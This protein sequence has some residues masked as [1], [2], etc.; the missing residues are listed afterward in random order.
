[1]SSMNTQTTIPKKDGMQPACPRCASL[2]ICYSQDELTT[3]FCKD[4]R[5]LFVEANL[6]YS[7]SDDGEARQCHLCNTIYHGA[8][9]CSQPEPAP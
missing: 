7:F 9:D 4:C 1:M 5:L 2:R 8:H 6:A 3:I